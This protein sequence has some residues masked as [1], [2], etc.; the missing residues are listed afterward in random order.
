MTSRETYI[1]NMNALADAINT[2]AG[3]TGKKT[4]L[5]MKQAVEGIIVPAG[6]KQITTTA[7]VNVSEYATAQV[8]D[9]ELLPQNIRK[10]IN[11]LGVSGTLDTGVSYT[12]EGSVVT[13][14]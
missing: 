14:I 12:Q 11:I 6:N 4:I 3:L 5:E 8:V 13:I 7:Q 1:A 10:D 2:R 9:A